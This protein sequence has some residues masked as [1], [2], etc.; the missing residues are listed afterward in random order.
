MHLF[1]YYNMLPC[2]FAMHLGAT[3]LWWWRHD[4]FGLTHKRVASNFNFKMKWLLVTLTVSFSYHIRVI[5]NQ[6]FLNEAG[7]VQSYQIELAEFWSVILDSEVMPLQSYSRFSLPLELG[8]WG[9]ALQ[10]NL[11]ISK[12]EKKT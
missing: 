4:V 3:S 6:E 12:N 10:L 2:L 7:S 1:N 11:R 9:R 8:E 5:E